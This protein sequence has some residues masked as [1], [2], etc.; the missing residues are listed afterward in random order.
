MTELEQDSEAGLQRFYEELIRQY[1]ELGS[2]KKVLTRNHWNAGITEPGFYHLLG[3]WGI[4]KAASHN[5]LLSETLAFFARLAE[6]KIPLREL[7]KEVSTSLGISVQTLHRILSYIKQGITRRRGTALVITPEEQPSLILIGKDYST[8]RLEYG[9]PYGSVSLPMGF[10]R[11][12][13]N[14]GVSI[15]RVLQQEVFT[16]YAVKRKM[17]YEIIPRDPKPFM[18]LAIADV[19]VAVY[20]V[21]LPESLSQIGNFS[22]QKLKDFQYVDASSLGKNQNLG[23]V[24]AGIEEIS[25]AYGRFLNT[26]ALQTRPFS[27][28]CLL[29][30]RLALQFANDLQEGTPI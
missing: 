15:L 6:E 22:S 8:Q 5:S 10:S 16:E 9:K 29:N 4:I 23:V 13:E 14:A 1:L 3:R 7:Y 17:P 21:M 11:R 12:L 27:E 18:Y 24:R 26:E 2:V 28:T 30:R 25:Q 19:E 20:R